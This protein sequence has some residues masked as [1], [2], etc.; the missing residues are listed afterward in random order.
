MSDFSDFGERT[1][2]SY[3]AKKVEAEVKKLKTTTSAVLQTVTTTFSDSMDMNM[4]GHMVYEIAPLTTTIKPKKA[5]SRLQISMNVMCCAQMGHIFSLAIYVND[6]TVVTGTK[7]D[8][9]NTVY[10]D[11]MV[12]VPERTAETSLLYSCYKQIS[13]KKPKNKKEVVV[14]VYA[15]Y[16]KD[17]DA[18]EK[19][20]KL[21][22]N[23]AIKTPK[24]LS[25]T[26]VGSSTLTIEEV[27]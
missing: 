6:K 10:A 18:T 9:E 2:D 27:V 13:V 8:K 5:E 22:I 17:I 23:E 25:Y 19:T 16:H 11:A 21:M 4:Q 20:A 7:A 12:P 15:Y 24:G 14:Q 3:L 1:T 26:V